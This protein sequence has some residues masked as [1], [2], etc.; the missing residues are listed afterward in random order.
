MLQEEKPI[1]SRI[2]GSLVYHK[3]RKQNAEGKEGSPGDSGLRSWSSAAQVLQGSG[4][5]TAAEL[6]AQNK[7]HR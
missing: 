4:A 7:L 2:D 1:T 3:C 6:A 5:A